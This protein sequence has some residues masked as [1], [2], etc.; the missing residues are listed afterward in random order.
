MVAE[1]SDFASDWVRERGSEGTVPIGCSF[2]TYA[3]LR[4]ALLPLTFLLPMVTA[5]ALLLCSFIKIDNR[6]SVGEAEVSYQIKLALNTHYKT[7]TCQQMMGKKACRPTTCSHVFATFTAIVIGI[8]L[9]ISS[10]LCTKFATDLS[11]TF[12]LNGISDLHLH[13]LLTTALAGGCLATACCWNKT[14]LRVLVLA[15]AGFTIAFSYPMTAEI[16]K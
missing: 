11:L 7:M 5:V 6:S 10:L 13:V 2:S 15:L 8:L 3:F 9:L 14:W 4:S 12:Y 16:F 1:G